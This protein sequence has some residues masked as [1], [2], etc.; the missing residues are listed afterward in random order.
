MLIPWMK[1]LSTTPILPEDGAP[2]H[3]S[4]I[5]NDY[6]STERIDKLSWPGHSPE[7]NASEHAWLWIRRHITHDFQPSTTVEEA[8]G[9]WRSE[10]RALPIT[11][12][13]RWIDG[14]PDVVRKIIDYGRKNTFY[15]GGGLRNANNTQNIDRDSYLYQIYSFMFILSYLAVPTTLRCA[16]CI[17]ICTGIDC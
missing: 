11:M 3:T 10:W 17:Q 13:N 15:D 1:S 5:A 14:I 4:R 7:V 8:K 2:A 12:I 6:L 16:F 9:Q